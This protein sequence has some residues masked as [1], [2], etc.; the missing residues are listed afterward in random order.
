MSFFDKDVNPFIKIF[1]GLDPEVQKDYKE[2]GQHLY[3]YI[4]FETGD[5]YNS[6]PTPLDKDA[7]E[8]CLQSGM[9]LADL[10]NEERQ[11]LG[12]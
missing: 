8:R 3:E 1:E 11:I 5:L 12:K 6:V 2:K 9:S 10:T 7:I 4:N